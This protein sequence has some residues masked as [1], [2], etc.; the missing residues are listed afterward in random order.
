MTDRNAQA[1]ELRRWEAMLA[2]SAEK[3]NAKQEQSIRDMIARL[4]QPRPSTL[5]IIGVLRQENALAVHF[6]YI[7]KGADKYKY[8]EDL[9]H[10]ASHPREY[11]CASTI[12]P[13]DTPLTHSVGNAGL[14]LEPFDDFSVAKVS[15]GDGG[16][17]NSEHE[18]PYLQ[19]MHD[20]IKK[21]VEASYNQWTFESSKV[22]GLFVWGD[23]SVEGVTLIPSPLEHEAGCN[24][25]MPEIVRL[26]MSDLAQDFP[27][28]RVFTIDGLGF[29]ELHPNGTRTVVHHNNIYP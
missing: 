10:A 29:A 17:W 2:Q 20:S 16:T 21:R 24:M 26:T 3:W 22:R 14:I 5:S 19:E 11:L 8:P 12:K 23:W 6:T 27:K 25:E 7:G 13:G 28:R 18:Y 9:Q 1:Q 4:K 15:V